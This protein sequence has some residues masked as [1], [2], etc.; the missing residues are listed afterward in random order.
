M[1]YYD[2]I[3][4]ILSLMSKLFVSDYKK[5]LEKKIKVWDSLILF[6][7]ILDKI[8]FNDTI[9]YVDKVNNNT[10]YNIKYLYYKQFT[11]SFQCVVLRAIVQ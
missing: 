11:N 10:V 9:Y 2:T 4:Y 8:T 6:S 5:N 1:F 3:G 7:R